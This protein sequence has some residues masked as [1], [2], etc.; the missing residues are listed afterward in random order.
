ML[1]TS[2]LKE[3]LEALRDK[4]LMIENR[5]LENEAA[6][7]VLNERTNQMKILRK[8]IRELINPILFK[9]NDYKWKFKNINKKIMAYVSEL[10]MLQVTAL[11]LKQE[12]ELLQKVSNMI[13]VDDQC[14]EHFSEKKENN[15]N[16]MMNIT[17]DNNVGSVTWRYMRP[18]RC[19]DVSKTEADRNVYLHRTAAE[20]RPVAYISDK[21]IDIPKPVSSI[22]N[23]MLSHLL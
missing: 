22:A 11:R 3:K 23:D 12:H 17:S 4:T 1:E 2:K 13:K 6:I 15:R 14:L 20:A 10:S 19:Y 9:I 8:K 16:G 21:S 7:E 5:I 18:N